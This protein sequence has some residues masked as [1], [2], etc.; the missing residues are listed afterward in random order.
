[1]AETW[2]SALLDCGA[3]KTVCGQER[4]NQHISNLSEHK[5]ENIKFTPRNNVYCSS[6]GRKIKAIQNKTFPAIIGKEH[7]N[8]QS[9]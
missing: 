3:S 9:D 7:I 6:D 1:M 2:S 5:Q 8:I 4:L